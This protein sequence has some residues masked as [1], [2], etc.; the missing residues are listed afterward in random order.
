MGLDLWFREDVARI[1]NAAAESQRDAL[2]ALGETPYY[3]GYF[4]ALRVVATA[5]GVGAPDGPQMRT[6]VILSGKY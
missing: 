5:F 6:E 3:R 4:A 1:L 2:E